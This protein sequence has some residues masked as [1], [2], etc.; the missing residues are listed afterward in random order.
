MQFLVGILV[1]CMVLFVY[2]HVNYHLKTSDDLEI[3]E[4]EQPSKE[5]LEEVCDL[6]QPVLFDFDAANLA[7][8]CRRVSVNDTYGA[9]DVKVRD[10]HLP[11]DADEELYV[12]MPFTNAIQVMRDDHNS[13]YLLES[14]ADFMDETGIAKE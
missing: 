9:F 6:R 7:N 12:P 4:V 10:L 8:V 13:R 5:K 14:S 3:F 1:F 2:L 11:L